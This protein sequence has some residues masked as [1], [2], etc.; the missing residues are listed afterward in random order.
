MHLGFAAFLRSALAFGIGLAICGPLHA[1]TITRT[2]HITGSNFVYISDGT[3]SVAPIDPLL[4]DVTLSFDN[5]VDIIQGTTTGLTVNSTDIPDAINFAYNAFFDTLSIG[6]ST[7]DGGCGG[8]AN[9]FCVII[10][11]GTGTNPTIAGFS[12]ITSAQGFYEPRQE[13]LSFS[14]ATEVPEPTS[15]TMMLLGFGVLGFAMRGNVRDTTTR[16]WRKVRAEQ[17]SCGKR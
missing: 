12:Q 17:E 14:D 7:V 5:S 2:F 11:G 8:G 16:G 10:S 9:T 6:S 13:S 15:W 3:N 4:L 1:T